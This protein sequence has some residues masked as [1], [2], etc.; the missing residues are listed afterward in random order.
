MRGKLRSSKGEKGGDCAVSKPPSIFTKNET[1]CEHGGTLRVFGTM[2]LTGDNLKKT[3]IFSPHFFCFLR[4][5]RL[6][7]TVFPVLT[8]TPDYFKIQAQCD[9]PETI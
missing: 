7:K 9:L 8:V 5:F 1:F 6:S 3:Q 2:R 4:R